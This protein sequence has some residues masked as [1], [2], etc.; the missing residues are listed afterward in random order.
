MDL[1][2]KFTIVATVN[3]IVRPACVEGDRPYPIMG[4]SKTSPFP[5]GIPIVILMILSNDGELQSLLLN[6]IYAVMVGDKDVN[7]INA[8][9]GKF[10]LMYK[11]KVGCENCYHIIVKP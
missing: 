11:K 1:E 8:E 4:I 3:S 9:P 2:Y 5:N 6:S 10:K 7:E